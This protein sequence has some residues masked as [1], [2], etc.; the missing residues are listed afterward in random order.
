MLHFEGSESIRKKNVCHQY[1]G[2]CYKTNK[3]LPQFFFLLACVLSFFCD[4]FQN[5]GHLVIFIV[6]V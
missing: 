6:H 4:T 1:F 2:L 3:S 5:K